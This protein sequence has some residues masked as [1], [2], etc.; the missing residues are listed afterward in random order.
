MKGQSLEVKVGL[1][2][3]VAAGLLGGF[4]FVLGGV[5]LSKGYTLHVDFNNPGSV[6]VGAP[7]RAGGVKVGTVAEVTYL[8]GKLDPRTGRRALVRFRLDM[9][10]EAQESIHEDA[11][12]YVTA[13]GVLGEQ[14]IA[15][16]PGSFDKPS[17]KD[18]A[19]VHGVDPP[20]LDL[21][22][23]LGYELLETIVK[24]LRNNRQ[25]FA[26]LLEN[27][28]S[29]LVSVNGLVTDNRER[30]GTILANVETASTE[31]TALIRALRGRVDGPEV[32]R[33]LQNLD[34]IL[35]RLMQD[36]GPL[37]T[38]LRSTLSNANDTLA[39]VGPEERARIRGAIEDA[40][41]LAD[42]A[43]RAA[44]DAQHIVAQI[45]AGQGTVGSLVMDEEIYDDLQEL[46]RDLKHNPWKF[47]WRE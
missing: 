46:L 3:L 45:R 32:G 25:E 44:G 27:A 30:I 4:L 34:R 15:V 5:R 6:Q 9:N 31:G 36:I 37:L 47:F 16:D 35:S 39:T 8:G 19:I 14:F 2:I 7:V 11:I 13:Q 29:L 18:G 43:N 42:R 23:S 21:A 17:L 28:V 10:E 33:I 24:A 1:L 26:D 41:E 20:R 22:F 12:F 40:A 38:D